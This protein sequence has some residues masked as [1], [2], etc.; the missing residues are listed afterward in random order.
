MSDLNNVV[1]THD[2]TVANLANGLDAGDVTGRHG[3]R[4]ACTHVAG[5]VAGREANNAK[6]ALP[7]NVLTQGI[8]GRMVFPYKY[9]HHHPAAQIA[10]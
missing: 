10:G 6:E 2:A 7:E 3:R 5:I 4:G 9:V 1:A 8:V